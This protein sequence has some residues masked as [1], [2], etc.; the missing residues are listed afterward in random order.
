MVYIFFYELGSLRYYRICPNIQLAI[1]L[2]SYYAGDLGYRCEIR[3]YKPVPRTLLDFKDFISGI[4]GS[5]Y[6]DITRQD[7]L[8]FEFMYNVSLQISDLYE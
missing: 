5:E 2:L 8:E 6:C 3:P 7:I 4:Y 1:N